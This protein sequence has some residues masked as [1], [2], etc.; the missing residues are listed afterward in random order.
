MNAMFEMSMDYNWQ[1]TPY[2]MEDDLEAM[3]DE[4][5]M[6]KVN[7]ILFYAGFEENIRPIINA[8]STCG[9]R[10]KQYH[11]VSGTSLK[12]AALPLCRGQSSLCYL[13]VAALSVQRRFGFITERYRSRVESN[14]T[15]C[16]LPPFA[17]R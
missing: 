13:R 5:K 17:Q 14:S 15:V 10:C 4:L 3:F 7:N 12:L 2:G 1:I 11:M 9:I 6:K 8:V 16:D